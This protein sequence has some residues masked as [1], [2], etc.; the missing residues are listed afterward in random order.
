MSFTAAIDVSTF[1]WCEQ[2]FNE[3]KN[4][5][6]TLKSLTPNVY[7]HI[8]SLKLP[9]LLRKE[10]YES[11]MNEFPYK[12]IE[13]IG[14]DFQRLTFEFLI[15]TFSN[16]VLYADDLDNK[17][18]SVPVLKKPHFS[19]NIDKE[20]QGQV[21]HMFNGEKTEHKFITYSYFFNTDNN[22]LLTAE[23]ESVEVDTLSYH[24][25]ED[26][27]KFFSKFKIK[28]EHHKKHTNDCYYDKVRKEVVSPF[29]SYHNQGEGEAQKLLDE[30][31]LYDGHFYNFDLRNDVYV[32]FIKTMGLTYHGH[33]VSDE[34]D[35]VPN[36]VKKKFNKNGRTFYP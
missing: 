1:I 22:L 15:D 23:D 19:E 12:M 18:T 21:C 31:F 6:I 33:D 25:E 30:A 10:L 2:D 8:R 7:T 9:V 34:G 29:S 32:R 28:F 24:S 26:I 35:N 14:H 5:Y 16:W 17:I 13:E 3:N 4:H 20:T 36:H 27:A 11:I